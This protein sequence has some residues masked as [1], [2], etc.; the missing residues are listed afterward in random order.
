[1]ATIII[2]VYTTKESGPE[3][4]IPIYQIEVDDG[5]GVWTEVYGSLAEVTAFLQGTKAAGM[6]QTIGT[7]LPY[8]FN[9]DHIKA[10]LHEAPFQLW[11][12]ISH[13]G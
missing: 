3:Y 2:T 9:E 11:P 1:M 8:R 10:R 7:F 5:K 4:K 13:G 12:E 6:Q